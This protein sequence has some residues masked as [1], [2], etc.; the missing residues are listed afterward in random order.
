MAKQILGNNMPNPSEDVILQ[1]IFPDYPRQGPAVQPDGQMT[2]HWDLG[3]SSLFQALQKNYKNEGILIPI[4]SQ[5]NMDTIQN[6]YTQ[7][8]G[9]TYNNLVTNLPDISGQTVFDTTTFTCNQFVVGQDTATPPNVTLAEW[10]PFA[11]MKTHHGDPNG[12]EAGILYWLCYDTL[13]HH[14]WVCT[15]AGP[16]ATAVWT[17]TV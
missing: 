5:S 3:L 2:P 7:F 13:N 12:Q 6:Q 17:Q 9:G 10:I 14:L 8:V 15:V 16:K 4:L 1:S 11:M